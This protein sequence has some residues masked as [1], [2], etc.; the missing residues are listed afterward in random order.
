MPAHSMIHN[1]CATLTQIDALFRTLRAQYLLG[2]IATFVV[3][4][5]LLLWNANRLTAQANE[6]RLNAEL[7]AI[8]PLLVAAI[9]PLLASRDYAALDD[10]VRENTAGGHLSSLEVLDAR[11]KLTAASGNSALAGARISKLPVLLAGQ[12]MGEVRVGIPTDLLVAAQAKL[13]RESI[14]I[15]VGVLLLGSLVLAIGAAWM[16]RG[17]TQLSLASRRVGAGDY[18]V[19]LPKSPLRE[20][21]EVSRA[22]NQMTAAVQAQMAE[23]Q[24]R[25][26]ALRRTF[27]T[28]SE[29]LL[30][31][32]RD[33]TVLDCNEALLRLYRVRR[34]EF[35][36]ADASRHGMRALWPD[37]SEIAAE[38]RPTAR[39]QRTGQPQR[40]VVCQLVRRDGEV[41]WTS[42]NATPLMRAGAHEPHAV[43]ATVTDITRHVLAEQ[44]L[45]AANDVLEARVLERTAELQRAKET[46]EQASH[47]KTDFLSRMSHELRTPLNAIL[48]FSQLLG[49]A[50][51]A[52]G[53]RERQ[54]VG[55]IESAGWH[56]LG[57]IN[58]VLDLSRIEAGAM[59]TSAE[60]VELGDLVAETLPM[61]QAMADQRAV[62][63]DTVAGLPGGAWVLADRI[64]LKQVL[65]NLLSNAVKYNRPHGHVAVTVRPAAGGRRVIAVSDTGRGF[66]PAQLQQL[67]QPFTR[68]VHEGQVIEGTGIGLVIT[69]R[70]VELMAGRLQ[71]ESVEGAGS[72]FL[73]DLPAAQAPAAAAG[74]PVPAPDAAADDAGLRR[75]LYVEDNPSNVDLL[76]QVMSLRP[77]CRL[78]V[79]ADGL[80]GLAL[81]MTERFDLAIID[82]DLPGIDGVELCQRLRS[83][84]PTAALPLLALSANAMQSDIR[85]AMQAGFDQYLTKPID[86]P[87]LLAEIDRLLDADRVIAA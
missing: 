37:G 72:I 55:Q 73:V 20:L 54:Q 7:Q 5:S 12:T 24:E 57:L 48:G 83:H 82:I 17:L 43:L 15:A 58:D 19:Q 40:D 13:L 39:A 81:A 31:Q 26:H 46:A 49:M 52:L 47:A 75:V 85:R 35:V 38:D 80:S 36:R 23:L 33:R 18:G 66:T 60:A 30:L 32:D 77:Q 1:R 42:V 71:V 59:S 53:E 69:Q 61:V 79:A 16:S 11:G 64:R 28:L 25:E 62:V 76:R 8:A 56:L 63:I 34:D 9:G 29:G 2:S 14:T 68:F 65:V 22:F 3:M 70:L 21:D 51:P 50:R 45:R 86:V 27:D 10:L 78:S 6:D 84:A 41:V 44:Q 74:Q 87:G 4:V 67:Y